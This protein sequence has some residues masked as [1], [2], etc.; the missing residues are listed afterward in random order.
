MYDL[1]KFEKHEHRWHVDSDTQGIVCLC[2]AIKSENTDRAK[3]KTNKY[4]ATKA[5]YGDYTYDSG[6][7][8]SHA[9]TLDILLKH[10]K[11]KRWERQYVVEVYAEGHQLFRTR[12]D[13]RVHNLDGSFTLQE[14]KSWITARRPDYRLK[15]K[16]LELLWLPKN[17]DHTYEEIN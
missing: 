17:L 11:I 2:G 8:A 16:C 10:G 14:I 4:N 5:K 1:K 15:R 6:K 9:A 12:V 13:F 3:P 7:E